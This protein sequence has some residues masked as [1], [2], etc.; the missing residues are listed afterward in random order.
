MRRLLIVL[1]AFA[2][3]ALPACTRHRVATQPDVPPLAAPPPPPRVVT[4]APA[5]EDETTGS[6]GGSTSA[7]E[8]NV[9][10][11]PRKQS[12]QPTRP[13]APEPPPPVKPE[14]PPPVQNDLPQQPP[15]PVATLQ[16]TGTSQQEAQQLINQARNALKLVKPQQLNQDGQAQ[17]Q[18]A[19]RF[20]EQAEQAF[21]QKNYVLATSLA[22]KAATIAAVL[23]GK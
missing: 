17:Y 7:P 16:P 23:V 1:V 2:A 8:R 18:A 6:G 10:R 22:D 12:A 14:T 13:K 21:S 15:K 9:P 5:T 20:V 3:L 19:T 4:P 11:T